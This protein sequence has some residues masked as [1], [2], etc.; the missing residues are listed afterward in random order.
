MTASS[1]KPTADDPLS[2]FLQDVDSTITN[3]SG[4]SNAGSSEDECNLLA[5]ELLNA[6]VAEVETG[7]EASSSF[8]IDGFAIEESTDVDVKEQEVDY[9]LSPSTQVQQQ[10]PGVEQGDINVTKTTTMQ[11][12]LE[13]SLNSTKIN[14]PLLGSSSA[15]RP[16]S[17]RNTSSAST[18]TSSSHSTSAFLNRGLESLKMA[19]SSSSN[20]S[21]LFQKA[22]SN[23]LTS[24]F[25]PASASSIAESTTVTLSSSFAE[26]EYS[27]GSRS[28]A[29]LPPSTGTSATASSS[30]ASGTYSSTSLQQ[31]QQQLLSDP[32]IQAKL[33]SF[34]VGPLLQ[35]E[36]IIMFLP[37]VVNV[38]TSCSPV[39]GVSSSALIRGVTGSK[40]HLWAVCMTFYRAML[41]NYTIEG[42][43]CLAMAPG[44]TTAGSNEVTDVDQHKEGGDNVE[45]EFV[46]SVDGT[47]N[48]V[49]LRFKACVCELN[50]RRWK[51]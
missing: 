5:E 21:S 6:V 25:G 10:E 13:P 35:G 39:T 47:S 11:H 49:R 12:P 26:Q 24:Q 44:V 4:Y 17:N 38:A 1:M 20:V 33:V 18:N 16:S 9:T 15:S 22:A 19:A 23:L 28:T 2:F 46:G 43:E 50:S 8:V 14:G 30:T 41:I 29:S 27:S 48:E 31:Q 45:E 37:H 51:I 3:N 42:L 36:R 40:D 7:K 34:A 32:S